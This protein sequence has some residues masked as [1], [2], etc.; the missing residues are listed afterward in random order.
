MRSLLVVDSPMTMSGF[1]AATSHEVSA[2]QNFILKKFGGW[3][4]PQTKI[5]GRIM[6]G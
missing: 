1:C 3:V 5:K 6:V 4:L 2:E